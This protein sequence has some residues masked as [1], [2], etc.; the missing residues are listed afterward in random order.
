MN[1]MSPNY[2]QTQEKTPITTIFII[3]DT[4]ETTNE[5]VPDAKVKIYRENG[6]SGE[7][8]IVAKVYFPDFD[9]AS[10]SNQLYFGLFKKIIEVLKNQHN[11]QAMI[12]RL[13]YEQGKALEASINIYQMSNARLSPDFDGNE[14]MDWGVLEVAEI[15]YLIYN[16]GEFISSTEN[17]IKY[18]FAW[19]LNTSFT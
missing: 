1:D 14:I 11:V 19:S 18:A 4:D 16:N 2:P 3:A 7:T 9:P 5:N 13:T 17:K 15:K 12:C 8:I 10:N 6:E